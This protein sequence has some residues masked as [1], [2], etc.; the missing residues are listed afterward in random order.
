MTRLAAVRASCNVAASVMPVPSRLEVRLSR[1]LGE[2][3]DLMAG[4]M[5]QRHA[6]AQAAQQRDVEQQIAEVVVLDDG[7][8]HGD[9]EHLVAEARHVAQDFA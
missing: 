1:L 7:A 9:D 2:P 3:A 4:P 8:V 6:D 5:H